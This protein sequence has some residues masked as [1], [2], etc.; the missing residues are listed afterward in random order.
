MDIL[1]QYLDSKTTPSD[2]NAAHA[3]FDEVARTAPPD[4]VGQ[5]VADAFKSNSTPSFADM[6]AQLFGH[7]DPRQRADVLNQLLRSVGPGLMAALRGGGLGRLSV[8]QDGSAPQVS[9]EQ[10][11][12]LTPEQIR[13]IAARA[14]QHDPT[15]LDK[16]GSIYAQHP[17]LVKKLGSAALAIALAGMATRMRG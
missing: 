3:H 12:Q 1:R 6:V 8:P 2:P 9:P 14:E 10:A 16:V 5:G 11:S 17:E 13:D 4:V 15:A 7:S